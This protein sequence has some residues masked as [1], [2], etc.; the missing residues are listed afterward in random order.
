[1]DEITH[2][3]RLCV[4]DPLLATDAGALWTATVD[5][6]T[7]ALVTLG[8]LVSV[9]AS[10]PSVRAAVDDAITAGA[11]TAQIVAVLDGL[12]SV[13]GLPRVVAAAPMFAAA[14]GHGEDITLDLPW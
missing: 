2:L 7:R 9:G 13:I 1:M 8:A 4:N 11:S 5:D 12:V 6:R 10:D 3:R 14:L